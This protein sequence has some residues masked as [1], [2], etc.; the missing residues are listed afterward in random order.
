MRQHIIPSS[1]LA[2]WCD[3]NTP[4]GQEPYVWVFDREKRIGKAR[5]PKNLFR[6]SHFYTDTRPNTSNP[7]W[8]EEGL[9]RLE[10]SVSRV[11]AKL[12]AGQQLTLADK[13]LLCAFAAAMY[14]RTKSYRDHITQQWGHILKM[15]EGMKRSIDKMTPD[16]IAALPRPLE[17]GGPKM[18]MD[19]VREIVEHP[20]QM[21]LKQLIAGQTQV[22]L[23]MKCGICVA[24]ESPGF[25]TSDAPCAHFDYRRYEN[26]R[27]RGG[28]ASQTAQ[29][30]LPLSP[31]FAILLGWKLNADL[32][33]REMSQ[34]FVD[35]VNCGT[36]YFSEKYFVVCK[37]TTR[38]TWFDV[39]DRLS[40][41]GGT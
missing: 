13:A 3:P 24:M 12:E 39:S 36:W 4:D 31:K 9:A 33:S 11:I 15:M 28:L 35:S 29:V 8:L 20:H 19:D 40:E 34:E 41:E 5:S 27:F 37:N 10:G 38:E 17:A 32:E 30:M 2:R 1:Y 7:L 25:I 23:H 6:A 16:Q 14:V 18:S 22:F 21:S 26:P